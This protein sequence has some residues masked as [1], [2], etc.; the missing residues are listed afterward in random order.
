MGYPCVTHE[1]CD[2]DDGDCNGGTDEGCPSTING[3]SGEL[4]PNYKGEG[5]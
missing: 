3:F 2:D 5:W 4:G 1:G